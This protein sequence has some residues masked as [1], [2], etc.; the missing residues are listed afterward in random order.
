MSNPVV[1]NEYYKWLLNRINYDDTDYDDILETLFNTPFT[2]SVA[3]D[4]NRAEDGIVLRSTFMSEEGWNT[5]PCSDEECS[6]LEM[7]IALAIRIE[8]DIMWDG[9]YDRTAKWFWEMFRNL[10][11]GEAD[12]IL[13]VYDILEKFMLRE[14]EFDG[15]G[16]L[17]PL[18]E[19][20]SEDQREVEIWYQAQLYLMK[21]YSF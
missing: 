7:M 14:Y 6:V 8:D 16:G 20:A 2:W 5:E 12:S 15:T 9:E 17:F 19:T 13:D 4:D 10:E 18:K 21:N 3:N 11:L 1:D